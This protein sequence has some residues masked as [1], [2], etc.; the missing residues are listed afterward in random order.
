MMK[1]GRSHKVGHDVM[2]CPERHDGM[3]IDVPV[4]KLL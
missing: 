3:V 2:V 1:V 4:R